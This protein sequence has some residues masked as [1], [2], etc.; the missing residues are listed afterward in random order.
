MNFLA[1]SILSPSNELTMLGNLSGDFVKGSKFV[2][3]H[4]D[5]IQGVKIHRN[6]DMFTDSHSLVKDAKDLVR[7]E[8]R[9]YSGVVIDMFFD[10]FLARHL[11]DLEGHVNK[12]YKSADINFN[13]LPDKFQPVLPYMKKHNWLGNY[14]YY[15]GLRKIMWQ[16]R[17]RIGDKSP[18]DESVDLLIKNE[19]EL[20]YLFNEFWV[21]IKN[22][23]L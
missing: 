5:I 18:L 4:P 13:H 10:H 17:Q 14:G 1:H 3:L 9:L 15:E 12:V 2:G 8:F 6:I 20:Q 22:E 21:Q 23:F 19:T 16:M 7:S 11:T